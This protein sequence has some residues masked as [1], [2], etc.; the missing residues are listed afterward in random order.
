MVVL[1]VKFA[2]DGV[3]FAGEKFICTL[4]FSNIPTPPNAAKSEFRPSSRGSIASSTAI[5]TR[6]P[7]PHSTA[8]T[9]RPQPTPSTSETSASSLSQQVVDRQQGSLVGIHRGDHVEAFKPERRVSTA[10]SRSDSVDGDYASASSSSVFKARHSAWDCLATPPE[11]DQTLSSDRAKEV[12]EVSNG[13]PHQ[14]TT[15]PQPKGPIS[16]YQ[17]T[18]FEQGE[19]N[20]INL[21][22]LNGDGNRPLSVEAGVKGIDSGS[23]ERPGFSGHRPVRKQRSRVRLQRSDS[24]LIVNFDDFGNDL[25]GVSGSNGLRRINRDRKNS[26]VEP[27]PENLT[28]TQ[29]LRKSVS[30]QSLRS[31]VGSTLSLFTGSGI[32]GESN[33]EQA[34]EANAPALD[35]VDMKESVETKVPEKNSKDFSEETLRSDRRSA[36]VPESDG[37]LRNNH[38]RSSSRGL[39]R[40]ESQSFSFLG[41]GNSY[42]S[43]T[44]PAYSSSTASEPK[45]EE[46]MWAFAQMT[47]Q[48]SVDGSFIKSAA[49]DPLRSK[50][51]Y[52]TKGI[53]G[54]MGG[55]GSL[56]ISGGPAAANNARVG[57]SEDGSRPVFEI[58]NPV[59]INK[60]EAVVVQESRSDGDQLSSSSWL[61]RSTQDR[62]PLASPLSPSEERSSMANILNV[63]QIATK[64]SYEICKNNEHVA[65]LC[66]LRNAYRLENSE[67]IEAPFAVRPKH[68]T[69]RLT[70]KV[71]A[72]SHKFTLNTKKANITLHIPVSGTPDF[73]TTAVSVQWCIRVEFITGTRE[74]LLQT[75]SP[76]VLAATS[77]S[78]HDYEHG[79]V[80]LEHRD[81][82]GGVDS[83]NHFI[84]YH[85]MPKAEVEAFDCVIPIKV[86]GTRVAR[87]GM[88]SGGKNI[89]VFDVA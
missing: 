35:P 21:N 44:N 24:P 47:G 7:S 16:G 31:A 56:G 15:S 12:S 88:V 48:F 13:R 33:V 71:Y 39:N 45:V 87:G 50:V 34:P 43:G 80:S 40:K 23:P 86:Y 27:G 82:V 18:D 6:L 32:F 26:Q 70:K 58:L 74:K 63:C 29:L 42:F 78:D 19:E 4:T 14:Q 49:F 62:D 37:L 17:P 65:Q 66:L 2:Q 89:L 67:I 53:G 3:F 64:V 46:I 41:S 76:N 11:D 75:S 28:F 81:E 79:A 54:G 77:M 83:E 8:P 68:Q 10:S 38:Q 36:E 1:T 85:A 30:M 72:E 55:G 59:I 25:G 52:R 9:T 61:R 69:G 22:P 51:M 84:H 5:G 20:V 73:Q 60:D 57:L